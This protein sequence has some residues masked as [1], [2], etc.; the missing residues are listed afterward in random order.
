MTRENE[1]EPE[2]GGDAG[3][4]ERDEV[5]Q[6]AVGRVCQLQGPGQATV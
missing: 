6:V 3:H 4:G 5:V 1:R 2:A